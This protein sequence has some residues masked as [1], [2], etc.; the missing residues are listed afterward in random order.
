MKLIIKKSFIIFIFIIFLFPQNKLYSLSFEENIDDFGIITLMY[1]R[2]DENK[3]PSTNIKIED[4]KKQLDL[5]EKQNIHFVN[6]KNFE[7]ELVSNKIKRKILLTIDDAF[8]SFYDNAWPILKEK[9]IPFILF[10]STREVGSF[11]YMTWEQIKELQKNNF[12][13]IGN[14]SHSHEYLVDE[15]SSLI[16]D[17]IIKSIKIFENNLG[18]NSDFFSYPFGEYSIDFKNIIKSLNFKYAFGQHSGVLDN[19][20]DFF[21]LP[22]FPI[23]EKYGDLKRFKTLTKTLPLK[24]KSLFPLEKYLSQSK[25]PPEVKIEFFENI[26][27]INKITCYSNEGNIWQKSKI[28]F[29][30][31]R[32]IKILIDEKFLGERGRINCSLR[33]DGGFW[34]WLGIQFVIAEE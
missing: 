3:Y 6:P 33:V 13:E 5:I 17:D 2:F 23:N 18:K 19:T 25:N 20:K 27:N 34:R 30:N 16:K 10:V 8:L 21:E 28:I 26:K 9:K 15:A 12:V 1:H 31:K 29:M 14:H 4:F 22:R 7:Y 11:N 32:S 24:Y